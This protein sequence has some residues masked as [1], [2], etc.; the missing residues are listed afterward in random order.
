MGGRIGKALLLAVTAGLLIFFG[1]SHSLQPWRAGLFQAIGPVLGAASEG[2]GKARGWLWGFSGDVHTWEE[3]RA[4][5]LA[6]LAEQEAIRAEN[7]TLRAALAL[8]DDGEAGAIPA[9]AV[10]FLR[11]GRDE[12]LVL[13]RGTADGIGVGD[14]VVNT[15]RVLG[16]TVVAV[17]PRSA[18][19]ILFSSPSRSTDVTLSS[20]DIRAV[21]RGANARE[22]AIELVPNDANVSTG[23]L[24][25]ASPRATGGRRPLL[26]GEIR[27]AR[28]AEHEVF[29]IVRAMHLF[30]PRETS[31]IVLLAP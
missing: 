5:L 4:R 7:E 16:G 14:I 1:A 10:A 19:V 12:Y 11:D 23:D 17:D 24:V 27:E 20:G 26:F 21:A 30:D 22:L 2:A 31:V 9:K 15:K 28:Q 6:R 29:K 13:N 8:R 3:E 25:L 18:R